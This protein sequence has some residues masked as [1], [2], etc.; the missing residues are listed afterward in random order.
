[1]TVADLPAVQLIERASFTTPWPPQAYRQELESNRLAAYLVGTVDEEVV[2]YGGIW[3]MVDEA[4]VTTFAVHP[5]YRRRRIGERLLLSLMDLSVDRHA[6]E[7]T[8]EVRLSNLAARRLYEK[9]GFRPV[10]IRPRYYSDNQ[11]DALIMTTEPLSAAPMRERIARLRAALDAAPPPDLQPDATLAP[12]EPSRRHPA[13]TPTRASRERPA[14]PRRSSRRATRRASRWSR[15]AR[16]IHANVV[17]SQVAL[18][19]ATGGIV[20]EVAARAHLRWIVPVLDEALADAGATIADLDAVAVTSGPGLAGSLLVGINFAKTLAWAHGKPLVGVNHLEG[21]LYAGWLLD[22][23]EDERDAAAV[24]AR[25]RWS[26]RAGT[27]SSSRCATTSPT[28]CSARPST[29]RRARRSTRSAACSASATRAGPRSAPPRPGRPRTTAPSRGRGWATR[30]TSASRASRPP[31]SGSSGRRAR[32]AGIAAD[33]RDAAAARRAARGARLG[34]P[35]RRGRRPGEEDAAG[36]RRDRGPGDRARRWRGGER[37]AARRG[38]R[39]VP[40]R[41]GS[42][43]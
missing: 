16:R 18:H 32:E 41:A 34:L 10:G 37:R 21:H 25:G 17:A 4:H 9:Y 27:R 5:R 2:A 29:T 31:P 7:A 22:P 19:A 39:P 26:C 23:G 40:R 20:P 42:G 6:R 8:L 28:G 24:P 36:R 35:G 14:G 11:E 12:A 30:T 43:S 38:S 1:M 15:A 3:L 33:D 13:A